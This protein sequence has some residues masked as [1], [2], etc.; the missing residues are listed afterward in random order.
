MDFS[1]RSPRLVGIYKHMKH[2]KTFPL[3]ESYSL[4][5][6][7]KALLD[8]SCDTIFDDTKWIQDPE[9][10]K[11]TV[12][13]NFNPSD[14]YLKFSS[15]KRKIRDIFQTLS[16]DVVEGDFK[17]RRMFLDTMQG[18]PSVIEGEL[19]GSGNEFL[20]A[21]GAP[22]MIYK[23]LD[24]SQN[25]LISLEGLEDTE[26]KSFTYLT[27]NWI[28]SPFLKDDLEEAKRI[29]TWVP[30][31]LD[32]LSGFTPFNSITSPNQRAKAK[33][34]IMEQKLTKDKLEEAIRLAPAEM[35]VALS[36]KKDTPQEF[37]TLLPTLDVPADFWEDSDLMGDLTDVGL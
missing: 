20:T 25:H 12:P 14:Y 4:S 16:F 24:L 37:Q 34:F 33:A 6:N 31:Y 26:V 10:G 28:R 1:I 8:A 15:D 30:V 13:G 21:E 29:G 23:E 17:V 5:D 36:R 18:F 11:I 32:I 3:F 9:T 27:D 2:I 7:Q 35:K 22:K 19:I